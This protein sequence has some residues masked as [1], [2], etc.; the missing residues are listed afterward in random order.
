MHKPLKVAYIGGGSRKWARILMSDLAL[1]Q[2]LHGEVYLYDIDYD[3]AM[4]N[5]IIGNRMSL[6]QEAKS[7][8]MYKATNDLEEAL[9]NADF[10]V[11]SIQ[12][13][14]IE[15]MESDLTIPS[16]YGI[17]QSVGDTTG[18]GGFMRALRSFPL[19]F[20][21]GKA[22]KHHCPNAWVLNFTNPMAICV[23]AL[24][25]AFPTIKAIGNCHEVFYTQELLAKA[26]D[27]IMGIKDVTRQEIKTAVTGVNHFTWVTK[28]SYKDIDIY[29]VYEAF[30]K[31]HETEGYEAEKDQW[32]TSTFKSAECVKFDLFKKYN[33]IA[34]AGD[35]HLAEFMPQSDYLIN[36]RTRN[37]YK[38]SLTPYQYRIDNQQRL[39]KE[40]QALV[41]QEKALVIKGSNEE[42]VRQMVALVGLEDLVTNVNL[43]NKGQFPHGFEGCVVESNALMRKDEVKPIIS[44][45]VSPS[46]ASLFIPA[47][48]AQKAITNCFIEKNVQKGYTAFSQDPLLHRLSEVE[49]RTLYH[50]MLEA[51]A[52]HLTHYLP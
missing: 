52:P 29:P 13:G 36:E 6:L 37:R 5:E 28:A 21:Y 22:I 17:N 48:N 26:L 34:A 45:R 4:Q 18:P 32:L 40:T 9:I 44:D 50:E 8:W 30:V 31:R 41:N 7:Q 15:A 3:A 16:K 33:T 23:K 43:P 39:I 14:G 10:V 51:N 25:Q 47:L 11:I 46:I 1:E 19:F 20:E 42:G 27:E 24:Y 38:F 35:R 49:K 2:R 12:P